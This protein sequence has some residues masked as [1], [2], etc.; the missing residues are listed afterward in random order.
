[1]ISDIHRFKGSV[2]YSK[3]SSLI[4]IYNIINVIRS[5]RY[6]ILWSCR[7]GNILESPTDYD[8]FNLYPS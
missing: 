3:M 7:N 8:I 2:V 1:M 4:F 6:I 5:K